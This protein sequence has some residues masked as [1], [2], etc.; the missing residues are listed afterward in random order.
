MKQKQRTSSLL[1]RA[2]ALLGHVL[3]CS[4]ASLRAKPRGG[5]GDPKRELGI[6]KR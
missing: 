2:Q 5:E 3:Q 4:S 6:E 1:P